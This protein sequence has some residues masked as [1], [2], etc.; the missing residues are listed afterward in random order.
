MRRREKVSE[1]AGRN[2]HGD[3]GEGR[4]KTLPSAKG[5]P[6][7]SP[8]HDQAF[9]MKARSLTKS[10]GVYS[11]D[12]KSGATSKMSVGS[13]AGEEG[14]ISQIDQGKCKQVRDAGSREKRTRSSQ[15]VSSGDERI[16]G[17]TVNSSGSE[18]VLSGSLETVVEATDQVGGHEH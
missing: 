1:K 7:T 2:E 6:S 14:S 10:R 12:S 16:V 15:H 9:S 5:L 18:E 13:E 4:T 3:R 11:Y 17:N 8:V